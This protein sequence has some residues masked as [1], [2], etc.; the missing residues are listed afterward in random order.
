MA[1]AAGLFSFGASSIYLSPVHARLIRLAEMKRDRR[2]PGIEESRLQKTVIMKKWK[3]FGMLVVVLLS[4]KAV[5]AQTADGEYNEA[6]ARA[7]IAYSE[8]MKLGLTDLLYAKCVK[9]VN[10]L[11]PGVIPGIVSIDGE[12]YRDDGSLNDCGSTSIRRNSSQ[13]NASPRSLHDA[14]PMESQ[15]TAHV[16]DGSDDRKGRTSQYG[17]IPQKQCH[18]NARKEPPLK[19][20]VTALNRALNNGFGCGNGGTHSLNVWDCRGAINTEPCPTWNEPERSA[21]FH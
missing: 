8:F 9:G 16:T 4:N 20:R 2:K 1:W 13:G 12:E 18:D 10:Y 3:L 6:Y 21:S 15:E 7:H 19:N 5:K 11:E 14:A 17:P